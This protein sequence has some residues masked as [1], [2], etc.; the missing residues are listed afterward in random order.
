MAA[1]NTRPRIARPLIASRISIDPD[2]VLVALCANNPK[3]GSAGTSSSP[4]RPDTDR[5]CLQKAFQAASK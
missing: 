4:E 1:R 5:D 2:D 3:D